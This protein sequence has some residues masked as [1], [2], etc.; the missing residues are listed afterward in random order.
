[1]IIVWKASLLSWL[2]S[3]CEGRAITN[4]GV[5]FSFRGIT[6][7]TPLGDFVKHKICLWGMSR[8]REKRKKR[9]LDG[10]QTNALSDTTTVFFCYRKTLNGDDWPTGFCPR[11]QPSVLSVAITFLFTLLVHIFSHCILQVY[12]FHITCY[13]FCGNPELR[14]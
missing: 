2:F 10:V 11:C 6:C 7:T 12:Y 13:S 1:M 3:L 14:C 5:S 4:V 8:A 9:V